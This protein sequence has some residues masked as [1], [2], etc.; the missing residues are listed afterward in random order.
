MQFCYMANEKTF[1]AADVICTLAVG[2]W[3]RAKRKD[4][5][6]RQTASG[7]TNVGRGTFFSPPPSPN[8]SQL[9]PLID[10]QRGFPLASHV[11]LLLSYRLVVPQ[12][13][14]A[15]EHG[16]LAVPDLHRGAVL[17]HEVGGEDALLGGAQHGVEPRVSVLIIDLRSV[18]PP[19][20]IQKPMRAAVVFCIDISCS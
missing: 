16:A 12:I 2:R 3:V 8:G 9:S 14:P 20:P 18:A 19:D 15:V 6:L 7:L 4:A 13:D 17:V 11:I 10:S 5:R 1:T